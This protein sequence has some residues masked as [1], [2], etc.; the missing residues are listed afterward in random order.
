LANSCADSINLPN[1]SQAREGGDKAGRWEK[2][3]QRT[4]DSDDSK[5]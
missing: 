3:E 2:G 1:D 4:E 5:V